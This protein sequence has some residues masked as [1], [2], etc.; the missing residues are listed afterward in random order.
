MNT[1]TNGSCTT[2]NVDSNTTINSYCATMNVDSDTTIASFDETHRFYNSIQCHE[3]QS[4]NVI[5]LHTGIITDADS[6]P[7]SVK[8][9][10]LRHACT[11]LPSS[12]ID[13]FLHVDNSH[14]EFLKKD[15]RNI[16]FYV[17]D[18]I[19]MDSFKKILESNGWTILRTHQYKVHNK[20]ALTFRVEHFTEHKNA[21]TVKKVC[22][23]S[24]ECNVEKVSV[25]FYTESFFEK[26]C[27]IHLGD[28]A[29]KKT[30][31]ITDIA[32]DIKSVMKSL[33]DIFEINGVSHVSKSLLDDLKL[34]SDNHYEEKISVDGEKIFVDE[35]KISTKFYIKKFFENMCEKQL[36]DLS[37]VSAREIN[38]ITY[39]IRC[40]IKNLNCIFRIY[41]ITHV[42][43]SSL[44]A[45]NSIIKV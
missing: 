12:I 33:N 16:Y 42:S 37:K 21:D 6:I 25:K 11:N 35:E 29:E 20:M 28:L 23:H 45:L 13:I 9:I 3:N 31:E 14:Y 2:M 22:E 36:G 43:K 26:L 40:S 15:M 1:T 17:Y 7:K 18:G 44:D 34:N 30:C 8:T 39:D 27:E 32:Y 19:G 4:C 24:N 38:N 10:F 41:G 5:E